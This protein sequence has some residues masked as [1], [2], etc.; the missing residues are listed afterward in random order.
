MEDKNLLN[1]LSK[2]VSTL[3]SKANA[4]DNIASMFYTDRRLSPVYSKIRDEIL[5]DNCQS[6]TAMIRSTIDYLLDK[7]E[8]LEEYEKLYDEIKYKKPEEFQEPIL[9]PI[10]SKEIKVLSMIYN[11]Q[12]QMGKIPL[13]LFIDLIGVSEQ[14]Y[15]IILNKFKRLGLYESGEPTGHLTQKGRKF[16]EG[17]DNGE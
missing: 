6:S 11:N 16:F 9:I 13:S 12:L 17:I 7:I 4:Y 2:H 1:E 5:R 10:S 3:E 15:Q 14:E 8:D